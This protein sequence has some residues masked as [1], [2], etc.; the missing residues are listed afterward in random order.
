MLSQSKSPLYR[1]KEGLDQ[2][3][4]LETMNCVRNVP[5]PPPMPTYLSMTN[6][7]EEEKWPRNG[8]MSDNKM[9]TLQVPVGRKNAPKFKESTSNND[10]AKVLNNEPRP[11]PLLE[12]ETKSDFVAE[13]TV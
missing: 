5:A 1:S 2:V 10:G 7:V 13:L 9:N 11:E 8:Q 12:E 3:Y 4:N 6:L